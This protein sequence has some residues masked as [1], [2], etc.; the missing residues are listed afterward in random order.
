MDDVIEEI[1][2]EL[3]T[4]EQIFQSRQTARSQRLRQRT[5]FDIEMMREVRLL[6]WH[7]ELLALLRRAAPG[8]GAL[9]PPRLPPQRRDRIHR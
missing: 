2:A 3:E 5:E 4:Q 9:H 7:R 1:K 8:N 6:Q